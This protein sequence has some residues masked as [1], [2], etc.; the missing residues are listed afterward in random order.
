MT[1]KPT[2][3]SVLMPTGIVHRSLFWG[4]ENLIDVGKLNVVYLFVENK[5]DIPALVE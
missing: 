1:L 2:L 4:L 3:T 5:F